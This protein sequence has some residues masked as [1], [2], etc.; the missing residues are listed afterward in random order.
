MLKAAGLPVTT[1]FHDLRHSCATI[2]L[3]QGVPLK[4]VSD[5]LGH[6]SIR[7]TADIYGHTGDDQKREAVDKIAGLF[8]EDEED[9]EERD[10]SADQL[11]ES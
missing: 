11:M 10:D 5:I 1:R 7:V 2:L 6:S 9:E 3:A 8:A 4:T